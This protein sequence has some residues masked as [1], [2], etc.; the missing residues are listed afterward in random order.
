MI[1]ATHQARSAGWG[2]YFIPLNGGGEKKS[3][4]VECAI[5]VLVCS[6]DM[7]KWMDEILVF[8]RF[9]LTSKN[10]CTQLLM[11]HHVIVRQIKKLH[12]Y[13]HH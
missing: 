6:S 11:L 12:P 8:L 3:W 10:A 2:F 4:L 9:D 13:L 7:R 1:K 5:T